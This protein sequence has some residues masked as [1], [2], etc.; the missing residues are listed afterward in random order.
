MIFPRLLFSSRSCFFAREAAVSRSP[1]ISWHCV[2]YAQHVSFFKLSTRITTVWLLRHYHSSDGIPVRTARSN[3]EN[4]ASRGGA[5]TTTITA[6]AAGT[7][8]PESVLV[9]S[10]SP[11]PI[12]YNVVQTK[13]CYV[14]YITITS[15]SVPRLGHA[16]PFWILPKFVSLPRLHLC[17]ELSRILFLIFRPASTAMAFRRIRD[18]HDNIDRVS[19]NHRKPHGRWLLILIKV[20]RS[21]STTRVTRVICEMPYTY[22]TVV[23]VFVR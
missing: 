4:L 22:I 21:D 20:H 11:L 15:P 8:Q 13:C 3:Y 10:V 17:S 16:V 18:I 1:L 19:E 9:P 14:T 7:G 2:L 12:Y 5:V 6:T 23:L